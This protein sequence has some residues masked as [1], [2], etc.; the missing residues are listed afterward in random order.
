VK[1]WKSRGSQPR[2][3]CEM[4]V[5]DL[6]CSTRVPAAKSYTDGEML[7]MK[8]VGGRRCSA[9]LHH[10]GCRVNRPFVEGEGEAEM[11]CSREGRIEIRAGTA[12]LDIA[13]GFRRGYLDSQF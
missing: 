2:R 1:S 11:R 10:R 5:Q 7:L 6:E 3:G 4:A 8:I 13:L 9:Q 12:F